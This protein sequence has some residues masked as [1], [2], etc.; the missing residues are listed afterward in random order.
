MTIEDFNPDA[1]EDIG[2]LAEAER[3]FSRLADYCRMRA[4]AIKCRLDGRIDNALAIEAK[5]QVI[6]DRLP[7]SVRW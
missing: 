5:M 1:T 4:R 3:A 7:E 6:Y 2:E